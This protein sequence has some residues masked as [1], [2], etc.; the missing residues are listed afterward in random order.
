MPKIYLMR[1]GLD[2]ENFVGGWSEGSLTMEGIEQVAEATDFIVENIPNL[3]AIYHSNL[4]RTIETTKI[5]NEKL[6]FPEYPLPEIRELNKGKLNGLLVS[7]AKKN[8][9]DYFPHPLIEQRYP[10]GESLLDLYNRV[11]LFLE[12]IKNYEASFLV[13]HRGFINMIYFILNDKKINYD[14]KQFCVDHAS[15]H[16]LKLNKIKRIY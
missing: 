4:Q 2:D 7:D 11:K 1:H 5:I 6:K 10:E 13:T 3:N 12:K 9:P 16:E 8:Y 15:I 14:K